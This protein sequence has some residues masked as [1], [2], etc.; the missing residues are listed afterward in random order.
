MINLPQEAQSI[1]ATQDH[2]LSLTLKFS[3]I[4][5]A[6]NMCSVRICWMNKWMDEWKN[7]GTNDIEQLIAKNEGIEKHD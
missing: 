7:Q 4:L 3:R 1:I 5:F 2:F 6:D